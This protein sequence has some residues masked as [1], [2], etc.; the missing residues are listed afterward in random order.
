MNELPP[1]ENIENS[2]ESIY[3]DKELYENNCKEYE[4]IRAEKFKNFFKKV[5]DHKKEFCGALK[6]VFSI[7][8]K[9]ENHST[10]QETLEEAFAKAGR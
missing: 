5:E 8:E 6:N 2:E 7:P 1:Q 4:K 10:P 3:N 9:E